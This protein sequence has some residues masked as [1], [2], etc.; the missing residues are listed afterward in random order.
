MLSC[1]AASALLARW[2]WLPFAQG[3][4]QA[5]G[6]HPTA[7]QLASVQSSL[8]LTGAAVVIVGMC[9]GGVVVGIAG[10][11]QTNPRHG[12]LA[13]LCSM[14]LLGLLGGSRFT[15]IAVIGAL[16]MIPIGALAA[17]VGA[18]VGLRARVYLKARAG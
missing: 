13:G 15:G 6:A 14:I 1:I 9:A 7:A 17:F 12:L 10:S 8:A 11:D 18:V 3:K 2:W 4:L 5:F 16:L